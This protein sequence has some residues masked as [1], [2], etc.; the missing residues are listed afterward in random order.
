MMPAVLSPRERVTLAALVEAIVPDAVPGSD[1]GSALVAAIG[2]LGIDHFFHGTN[3][4]HHGQRA[5]SI[6][7]LRRP[8]DKR[9][10]HVQKRPP[11]LH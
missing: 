2:H 3:V 4:L 5:G 8:E 1:D 10:D 6:Q 7:L 11:D 9:L